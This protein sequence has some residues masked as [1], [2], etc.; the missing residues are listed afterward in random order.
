MIHRQAVTEIKKEKKLFLQLMVLS[1]LV[2]LCMIVQAY[3]IST[4]LNAFFLEQV[5]VAVGLQEHS[6]MLYLL[7]GAIAG[8]VVLSFL[9]ERTAQNLALH[10][11]RHIRDRLL[12]HLFKLGPLQ[13]TMQGEVAHLLTDGLDKVDSYIARYIPQMMY[14]VFIPLFVGIAMMWAVPWIGIILLI[15]Y[16]LIP[17]FMIMIGKKAGKMN[18]AQW[19]RMSFLSGHF[20]DVLQGLTTLKLFNRAEEQEAVVGRLSGEFRDSTLKVLRVAFLSAFVLELISTISTAIIAV[21]LGVALIYGEVLYFPAFFILLLAPEF[22]VP[23]RE[24]GSAFHTGMGGEVALKKADEF[25]AIPI[26]EPA[27]AAIGEEDMVIE[28]IRFDAVAFTY[29]GR[30]EPA[31]NEVQFTLSRHQKTILIGE[32]GAGKST[33]ALLLLRLLAPQS[34]RI[35]T[36]G[37]RPDGSYVEKD[38][39]DWNGD[40]WRDQ[41][42]FMAQ[43]SYLF[44]GSIYDNI[45]FGMEGVTK[46][47]VIEATKKAEAYSFIMD[48]PDGFDRVLGE[49]GLGLSGGEVQRIALAR[50]FLKKAQVLVLDEASAHLD[51]ETEELISKALE[52]L[53]EE[54]VVLLIGHRL[55][56]LTWAQQVLVMRGGSIQEQGTVDELMA[57]DGYFSRLAK[58]GL[59]H[60]TSE[61]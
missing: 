16:P 2:T 33:I 22:Y 56:M 37:H 30:E 53:M 47:E 10:T 40:A 5:T 59:F 4:F 35:V 50:A 3:G 45:V 57:Q 43:K 49:G 7:L 27:S 41:I 46:E 21:Y 28:G 1:A 25:L 36:Y 13:Q 9:Q 52:R 18:E 54:K 44:A 60:G 20:L 6:I 34:G 38:L 17:F 8:R 55:Q 11:K 19:E 51:V 15:T 23:L 39:Q 48:H 26:Q 58:E 24:L 61:A 32:S 14:A 29:V 42:A 31:V 12:D